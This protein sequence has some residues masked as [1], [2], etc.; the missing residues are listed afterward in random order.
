MLIQ[1]IYISI[2]MDG[3]KSHLFPGSRGGR[4]LAALRGHGGGAAS[5]AGAAG[6]G[7]VSGTGRRAAG[8]GGEISVLD[9]GVGWKI[10][11][12]RILYIYMNI[13]V[14]YVCVYCNYYIYI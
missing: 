5:R 3:P 2:D 4:P 11:F 6:G 10:I 9:A 8:G 1:T 7:V 14:Y 12:H 13:Y